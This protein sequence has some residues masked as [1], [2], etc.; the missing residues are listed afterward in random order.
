MKNSR[1]KVVE[2]IRVDEN[3][4]V[5]NLDCGHEK[6]IRHPRKYKMK[7]TRCFECEKEQMENEKL[8]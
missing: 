4:W 7:T 5:L 1:H 8:T 2:I 6:W 3:N